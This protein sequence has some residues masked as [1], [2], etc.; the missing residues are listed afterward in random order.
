MAPAPAAA[1]LIE[2][3][4]PD[5]SA[6]ATPAETNVGASRTSAHSSLLNASCLAIAKLPSERS[7]GRRIGRAPAGG[8]LL[9]DLHAPRLRVVTA[10]ADFDEHR[11]L[12]RDAGLRRAGGLSASRTAVAR[13]LASS[14]FLATSPVLS[15]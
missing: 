15:V 13:F 4:M 11:R 8:L 1:S 9:D 2:L 14:S 5:G 7:P 12:Q 3:K 6:A 10:R